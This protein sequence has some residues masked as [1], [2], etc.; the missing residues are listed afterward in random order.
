[1][2]PPSVSPTQQQSIQSHENAK[3]KD[4][5]QKILIKN[6]NILLGITEGLQYNKKNKDGDY[7]TLLFQ[8]V[9]FNL[10]GTVHTCKIILHLFSK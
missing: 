2:L 9:K 3:T 1:M 8:T 6:N 5:Q 4:K 10:V 7:K